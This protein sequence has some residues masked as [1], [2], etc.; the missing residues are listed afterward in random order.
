MIIEM[1]FICDYCETLQVAAFNV[2]ES[3][4]HRIIFGECANC[5]GKMTGLL[6]NAVVFRSSS[7]DGE[8]A[9]LEMLVR[10]ESP[11]AAELAGSIMERSPKK[12]STQLQPKL[13][14]AEPEEEAP[15]ASEPILVEDGDG[16]ADE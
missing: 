3:H 15:A 1:G 4:N 8:K 16:S 9:A 7:H 11:G 6:N 14:E 5:H 12:K 13:V 2:D 10:N